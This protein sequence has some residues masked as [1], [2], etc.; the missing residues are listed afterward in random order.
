MVR[1]IMMKK[2]DQRLVPIATAFAR[3]VSTAALIAAA[4]M[5]AAPATA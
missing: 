1:K 3:T 5:A 2:A 4:A